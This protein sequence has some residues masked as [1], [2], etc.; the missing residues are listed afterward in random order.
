MSVS[1]QSAI[2][3]G[4]NTEAHPLLNCIKAIVL[5]TAFWGRSMCR[6]DFRL[7]RII[8]QLIDVLLME[9]FT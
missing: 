5:Q 9:A 7:Q 2:V 3:G 4:H 1:L 8:F 6:G